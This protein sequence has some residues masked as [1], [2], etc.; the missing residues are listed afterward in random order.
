MRWALRNQEKIKAYFEEDGDKFLKG[1]RIAW[2]K[3]FSTY[4]DVEPHIEV[5]EGEPYPILNVDDAGH[6][7]NTIDFYVIKKHNTTFTH[8]AFKRIHW[9][10]WVQEEKEER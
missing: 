9:I 2:I 6:S 8:L 1:S 4:P 7:F 5:V 10:I 3:K